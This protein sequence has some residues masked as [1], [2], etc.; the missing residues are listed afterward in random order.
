MPPQN[1]TK[2]PQPDLDNWTV[3]QSVLT[4]PSSSFDVYLGVVN[5][6][7]YYVY[8]TR[9]RITNSVI[10]GGRAGLTSA[11]LTMQG[12]G[13]SALSDVL[14]SN[15]T[16][17]NPAP[18]HGGAGVL[19]DQTC[20]PTVLSPADQRSHRPDVFDN[21]HIVDNI[22]GNGTVGRGAGVYIYGSGVPYTWANCR[23]SVRSTE[24]RVAPLTLAGQQGW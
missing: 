9:I 11:A 16:I 13:L 1:S 2:P 18:D 15:T 19:L 20:A 6:Y 7:Q 8:A 5:I 14:V 22:I 23:V 17:V 12:N 4:D 10:Y 21:L 24:Q 3:D